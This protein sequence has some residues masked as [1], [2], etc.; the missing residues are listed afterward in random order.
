ML[1]EEF[2]LNSDVLRTQHGAATNLVFYKVGRVVGVAI[3]QQ[4]VF[5]DRPCNNAC[6]QPSQS[7]QLSVSSGDAPHRHGVKEVHILRRR[8][9]RKQVQLN[10]IYALRS[11]MTSF[12]IQ[13]SAEAIS[14]MGSAE[15]RR[16]K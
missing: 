3:L 7:L 5:V 8:F 12:P 1:P 9:L 14:G 6:L 2:P 11:M 16:K 13:A 15:L 10:R 4:E